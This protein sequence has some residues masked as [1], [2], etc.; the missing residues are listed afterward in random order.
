MRK[1]LVAA[2]L[3][4]CGLQLFAQNK[5]DKEPYSVKKFGNVKVS[6]VQVET[7][8]GNITITGENTPEPRVEIY[9]DQ[10]NGRHNNQLSKA[11]IKQ[12]IR[13]GL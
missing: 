6:N 8:G 4:M 1:F 10:N 9:V 2:T 12:K 3:L 11:E 7:S 5:N 13:I